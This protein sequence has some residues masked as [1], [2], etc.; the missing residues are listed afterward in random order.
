MHEQKHYEKQKNRE[1]EFGRKRT[2]GQ[3]HKD[4]IDI[5]RL[6]VQGYSSTYIAHWMSENRDYTLSLSVIS[7]D[8]INIIQEWQEQYL[9]DVNRMKATELAR[10][11]SLIQEAWKGWFKS[12]DEKETTETEHTAQETKAQIGKVPVPIFEETKSKRKAENRD[13]DYK[14]LELIDKL[15]GRRCKILGLEA[16]S[17][18]EIKDWRKEA[19]RAGFDPGEEFETMVNELS[20]TKIEDDTEP[21]SDS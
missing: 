1:D 19:E 21:I 18:H 16:P 5:A 7:N 20:R 4:R 8:I 17:R 12:Q 15:I 11:D 13:G 10:I 2:P 3:L 9:P 14:F 6:Y